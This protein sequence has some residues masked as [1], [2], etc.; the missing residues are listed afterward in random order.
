MGRHDLIEYCNPPLVKP[1]ARP[2]VQRLEDGALLLP[3]QVV[4]WA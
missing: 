4:V 1:P 3:V 2:G